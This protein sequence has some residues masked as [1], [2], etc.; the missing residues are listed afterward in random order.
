LLLWAASQQGTS[1]NWRKSDST[2]V[3][4]SIIGLYANLKSDK[5]RRLL[6]FRLVAHDQEA[7]ITNLKIKA[8]ALVDSGLY[9][10]MQGKELQGLMKAQWRENEKK[11]AEAGE[12][13]PP[14]ADSDEEL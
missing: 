7:I 14:V 4:A 12:E 2:G 8:E 13:A 5:I 10:L 6:I 9:E 3:C 11:L 1:S